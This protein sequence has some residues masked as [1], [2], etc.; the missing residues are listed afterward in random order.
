MIDNREQYKHPYW[1]SLELPNT[2]PTM[3]QYCQLS[4]PWWRASI[5]PEDCPPGGMVVTLSMN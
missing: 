5:E 2:C 1:L 4:R 3:L